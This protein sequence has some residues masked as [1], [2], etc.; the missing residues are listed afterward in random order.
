MTNSLAARGI[1]LSL[2]GP[3]LMGVLNIT[4]DSFSDGGHHATLDAALARASDLLGGG[5]RILDVGGESTRPGAAPVSAE[6]EL[7]RVLPVLR[8]L[9]GRHP[10]VLLSV[11]TSKA[12][13]ARAALEAGAHLVN[14]VT[15]L[16]D[17]EMPA[18]A[19]RFD[20]ALIL[21]HMRGEPSTMQ[22]GEIVYRDVVAEVRDHLLARARLA[23]VAGVARERIL[24]DPGL[25]FGKTTAHNLEL[26][27]RLGELAATGYPIVYGPSRKRFLG[28]V[29]RREVHD[30]DRATAAACALAVSAGAT[31]LRVHDPAACV[32]AIRV[33]A[34]VRGAR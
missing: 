24:L 31:I 11:D 12:V 3:V 20:A 13:V 33:A 6:L 34:A 21:M 1:V 5:A 2:D 10:N 32:D 17:P 23:V 29:T 9:A 4:P 22:A 8:A 30:R 15:A 19:A 25:G 14:D 26:T 18:V 16:A 7:E 27:R 28:E